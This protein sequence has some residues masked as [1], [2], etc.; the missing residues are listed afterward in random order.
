MATIHEAARAGDVVALLSFLD[1]DALAL[2]ARDR[3]SRTPLHLAS[4]AGH[5]DVVHTLC[6]RRAD[7]G[8][9]AAANMAAIHFACQKGHIQVVRFLLA[10]GAS[11]NASTRKGMTPLHYAIQAGH[12]DIAKLLIKRGASL[13]SVNKAGKKA[14]DLAKDDECQRELQAVEASSQAVESM[15]KKTEAAS[16]GGTKLELCMTE[17]KDDQLEDPVSQ[18]DVSPPKKKSKVQLSHLGTEQE[19]DESN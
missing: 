1:A 4:W 6:K 16:E 13:H 2:N 17:N 9:A 12:L 14:I 8:A 3:H 7:V 11:V 10:A 5:A 15:A 18:G 19:F